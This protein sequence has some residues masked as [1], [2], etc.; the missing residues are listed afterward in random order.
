MVS[1]W[2]RLPRHL[3]SP[4]W[5]LRRLLPKASLRAIEATIADSERRHG[6]QIRVAIESTLDPWQLLRG[7][8]ARER[9]LQVFGQ[10][11]VW[12]TEANNGVLIYVLLADRDVEIIADRGIAN[13]VEPSAWQGICQRMELA[14][15]RG[16]FAVGL[17]E[18]IA[19]V[20]ALLEAHYPDPGPNTLAD[21]PVVL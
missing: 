17:Q 13:R 6:G 7:L 14:F 3:L 20:G 1:R 5:R 16:D 19:A 11:R 9:A 12:D 2:L 15:Q 21:A 18:A 10:Y 4:P 8:E